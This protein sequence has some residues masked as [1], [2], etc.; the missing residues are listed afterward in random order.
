MAVTVLIRRCGCTQRGQRGCAV[1]PCA[2]RP[3]RELHDRA[4]EVRVVA[5]VLLLGRLDLHQLHS[6]AGDS[7]TRVGVGSSVACCPG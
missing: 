1:A 4:R 3:R 7:E 2:T 5:Q 6:R